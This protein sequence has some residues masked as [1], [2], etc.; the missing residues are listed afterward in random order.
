MKQACKYNIIRF[1]P[2][3]ETQEF[4][5]IGI[6]LYAPESQQFIFKLLPLTRHKRVTH[7]F[8]TLDKQIYK[9]AIKLVRD[10]LTRIQ[11]L[12]PTLKD[13][14][15]LYNE[16]VRPREDMICYSKHYV[17]LTED[18]KTTV[19]EQ[20]EHYVQH[21]F[22]R[23]Q[24]HEEKMRAR[25]TQ[26][27]KT[28]H[29]AEYFT[30]REI[31]NTHYPVRLPFVSHDSIPLIIKPIHFQHSQSKKLFDHGLHW[32]G[33]MNQ[34]FRANAA[35]PKKTLF[36]YKEPDYQKGIL[37]EA[38]EDIYEQIEERGIHLI[39]INAQEKITHFAQSNL[40]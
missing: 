19:D 27:L 25:I 38:F 16:L 6:V 12:W 9:D 26:L 4:A 32:L 23:K 34:L 7:F 36:T 39:D 14:D 10:E 15:A 40:N 29:L 35:S 13:P 3:A 17:R 1:Q 31:G 22:T 18:P 20:F 33:T 28:H 11:T 8:D 2:Y 21:S 5:N 30:E 37:R 24:G